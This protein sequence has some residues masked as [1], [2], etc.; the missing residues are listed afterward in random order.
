MQL[1]KA[2]HEILCYKKYVAE[3]RCAVAEGSG[4]P[5]ISKNILR[6]NK[7]VRAR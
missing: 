5:Q 7:H 2:L 4:T 1:S 6:Y 3:D